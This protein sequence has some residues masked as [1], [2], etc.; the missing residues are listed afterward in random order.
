MNT[1]RVLQGSLIME[2]AMQISMPCNQTIQELQNNLVVYS[3]IIANMK[4]Q[5]KKLAQENKQFRDAI[6]AIQANNIFELKD[7][8]LGAYEYLNQH[9]HELDKLLN[10]FKMN[11]NVINIDFVIEYNAA[12]QNGLTILMQLM[13]RT[14]HHDDFDLVVEI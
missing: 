9:I 6:L 3:T 14:L 10:L 1:S 5:L 12:F 13:M 7:E 4:Y 2:K 8:A 11:S